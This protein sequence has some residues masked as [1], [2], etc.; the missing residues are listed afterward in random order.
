MR[1]QWAEVLVNAFYFNE[2]NC[3]PKNQIF[4]RSLDC[5]YV[6]TGFDVS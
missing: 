3:L 1:Y 6:Y 2:N 5:K 4:L